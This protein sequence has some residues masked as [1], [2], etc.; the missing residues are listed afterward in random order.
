MKMFRKLVSIVAAA[1]LLTSSM[2]FSFS[3]NAAQVDEASAVASEPNLQSN[4]ADGVILHAFNWSYDA[5]KQNLPQIAAAGYST[6]QTSPVTQPKDYGMSSDVAMQWPKL[7]QP[8][9][10]SIAQSSWL[11][12]KQD[13]KDLCAEADMANFKEANG[14]I[15]SNK[16]HTEVKDY[17]PTL[18]NSYSTYFHSETYNASDS[19]AETMTRGHVSDCPDLNTANSYVQEK[20]YNLLKECIDCGV[21]G[22]RFDAAKHIETEADGSVYSQFWVNTLDKAATY[23]KSKTGKDLFAYGEILNTLGGRNVNAYTKRMRVTEN[24][25]S[26]GILAGVNSNN[27]SQASSTRYQLTG[28]ANKAVVW[29]ESHDTH[30]GKSG[31]AGLQNTADVSD[32]KIVNAWAIIA[33]KKGSTPLYFAR[34]G[35]ALM[36]EAAGDL[37]YK[38]TVVSEINK[39]HNAFANVNSEKVGTSGSIV[40]VARGDK[41][42]VL[43]NI[44]GA[45]ASANVS[46]TGLADGSYTDT[47]TGNTFTVSGGTLKGN[48][49]S[50][51]VAVIYNSTTTPKAFASVE[52][53]SFTTDTMVVQLG[54]ENAVSGTYAL[55]NSAPVSF[56]G[57]PN[58]RIGSDYKVGETITLNLTATDAAGQTAKATYFYTKKQPTTSGIYVFLKPS[59]RTPRISRS[60]IPTAAGPVRR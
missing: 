47:V 30:M 59:M 40:Y 25:Y 58:I 21:D 23:Y 15:N 9:S 2:A 4:P 48:I 1:T 44:T 10:L 20:I 12:T 37:T 55:E 36:G 22:F 31:S 45:S 53:G 27:A 49:G 41:G 18:Y 35:S 28:D 52:S 50:T 43:S 6:V 34:P 38:S 7:Y 32:A 19:S 24:K 33:A 17:E 5:I 11:G 54:F 3:A 51:G 60:S 56:T 39:F 13:L 8:V 14:T 57:T 16:L 26:D 29:A 46:G 42:V